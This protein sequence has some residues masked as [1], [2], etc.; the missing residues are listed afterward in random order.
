MDANEIIEQLRAWLDALELE[1]KKKMLRPSISVPNS[2]RSSKRRL[3]GTIL[4]T[5]ICVIFGT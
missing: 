5:M 4:S 2:K 3:P 1:L